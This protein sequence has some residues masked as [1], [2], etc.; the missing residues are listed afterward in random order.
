ME[1]KLYKQLPQE[2]VVIRTKVFVEE[3]GFEEEYDERDNTACHLVAFENEQP[4]AT[5]RF[6]WDNERN[7]YI[8]GRL[9][10]LPQY[11]GGHVG[12]ALM[13][14]AQAQ[15]DALSGSAI[16]LHAQCTASAF[17]EKQG[18]QKT[19]AVEPE[20]GCPHIWMYKKWK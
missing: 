11:R 14:E 7:T 3:Q 2:A 20:Q 12:A 6:F 9:A 16:Y 18:Y 10:V 19:G 17:Y 1:I 13:K 5:C 15:V 4:I 8:L